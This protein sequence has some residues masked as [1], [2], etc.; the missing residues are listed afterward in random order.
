MKEN[1][2]QSNRLSETTTKKPKKTIKEVIISVIQNILIIGLAIA[3]GIFLRLNVMSIA[4]VKGTSM[5]PTLKENE[6]LILNRLVKD[7]NYGDI[8]VL[9]PNFEEKEKLYIKR[10]IG[11]EG[12]TITIKDGK[13]F[14]NGKELKET[15]LQMKV[16]TEPMIPEETEWKVGKD[17]MFVLGDNRENSSDSRVFGVVKLD[18][19]KGKA[20]LRIFPIDK[21]GWIV[22]K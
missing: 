19:I 1:K 21:F 13:V 6:K 15:Y 22:E 7:Y 9:H 2:I 16:D 10:V 17:E 20:N 18:D 5:Y 11:L 3:F 8:V 14:R 12:D 4:S